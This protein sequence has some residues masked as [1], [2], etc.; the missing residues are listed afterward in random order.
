MGDDLATFLAGREPNVVDEVEWASGRIR[1]RVSAYLDDECPPGRYITSV[2]AVVM[3]DDRVLVAEDHD[4]TRHILPGGRLEAGE[5]PETAREIAE[6]TGWRVGGLRR[7]GFVHFRH[8][9][10]KPLDYR[11][12]YPSF[13]QAIYRA[14]AAAFEPGLVIADDYVVGAEFLPADKVGATRLSSVDRLFL[15]ATLG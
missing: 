10:P 2:R 8:L 5:L 7:L 6:E 9:T 1:L 15:A 3:R 12:P 11:Y 13:V 4:G 14:E